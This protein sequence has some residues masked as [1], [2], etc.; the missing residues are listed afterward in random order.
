MTS[1]TSSPNTASETASLTVYLRLLGYIKPHWLSFLISVLGFVVY[2]AS[3]PAMA[4]YME[5][6]LNFIEAEERG[7]LWQPSLIIIAI[8]AVRGF[9]GFLGNF[10]ISKVSFRIVDTLRV[11][12]FNHMVYLP[13]EFYERNDS[14][15]LI[16][17]INF[18]INNVTT[19]STEALKTIIR[20]GTTLIGLLAYLFYKD[21]VL[22]LIMMTV[23]PIIA[24][25]VGYV[26]KRLRR[27]SS[28]VQHSMG[29]I[30]QVTSE[31]VS[32]YRVMRSFGGETYEK[33]RFAAASWRNYLQNVK[34]IFTSALNTPVIQ[35]LIALAMGALLWVALGQMQIQDAGAFVAYF[36]AVGMVQKTMRQL[37]EVVPVIQKGVAAADSIFQVLDEK[38]EED[39]GDYVPNRVSGK[40]SVRDLHFTYQG[41]DREALKGIQLDV[42]PGQVVA[43]V[44]KSGSGKST[45]MNLLTRFYSGFE[46]SITI[47]GT[48]IREFTL[49]SL[50]AQIALVTQQVVL[51]N[52]T[53]AANIAYGTLNDA[54]MDKVRRAA[55]LAYASEFIDKLPQGYDTFIGEGGAKLSGGQRQRLA[56]ARAIFKD[57]PILILDEATSALDNESERY[58]Q[59]ALETV[60]RGRTTF[61]VAHRLSTIEKADVIVV[62]EDGCIVEQGSHAQLMQEQGHYARLHSATQSDSLTL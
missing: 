9:G 58:I 20:E 23:A 25:L 45:L 57:A 37:S 39:N 30:T 62:M 16:S 32:G 54:A 43:L 6:L 52:D 21:W 31:M 53:V 7:P 48:D 12:L 47:D 59:Q 28:K 55:D 26:G 33:E 41:S 36:L 10:F 22:T 46:G 14:G 29:D 5:Y 24:V 18:N 50:R 17:I 61:V 56:I 40:V 35:L 1:S 44:G 8:I 3:Q 34:V 19:A 38:T 60:S 42:Q 2:S 4:Q 51:F 49:K 11:T 13:G 27:L 15:K